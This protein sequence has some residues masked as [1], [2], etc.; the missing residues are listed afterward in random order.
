MRS[1]EGRR[2]IDPRWGIAL[3]KIPP[4]TH[5]YNGVSLPPRKWYGDTHTAAPSKKSFQIV[6]FCLGVKV[7][8]PSSFLIKGIGPASV[9][10]RFPKKTPELANSPTASG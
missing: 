6:N 5:F 3:R 9:R 7:L 4:M 1:G 10:A 8:S 2:G